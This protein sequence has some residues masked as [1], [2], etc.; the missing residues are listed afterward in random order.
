MRKRGFADKL[1]GGVSFLTLRQIV[2][3]FIGFGTTIILM[4]YL[5]PQNYGLYALVMGVIGLTAIASGNF[6]EAIRRYVPEYLARGAGYA[7]RRITIFVCATRLVLSAIAAGI[8]FLL[9]PYIAAFYN[10]NE[11]ADLLRIGSVL[12]V[13]GALSSIGINIFVG[14]Q[15]YSIPTLATTV[16][17]VLS[18]VAALSIA[19]FHFSLL[20]FVQIYVLVNLGFAVLTIILGWSLLQRKIKTTLLNKSSQ[21]SVSKKTLLRQVFSYC[22]PLW[23]AAINFT[24]YQ[25]ASKV[26]LGY[27]APIEV[28]GYFS[29]AKGVL[30]KL[31]NLYYQIPV[32]LLPALSE[33]LGMGEKRQVD[34]AVVALSK[35]VTALAVMMSAV[36][37]LFARELIMLIGGPRYT[38][39]IFLL[40]VLAVQFIFRLPANIWGTLYYIHERTLL[41]LWFNLARVIPTVVLL[42]AIVPY[43]SAKGAAAVEAFSYLT[44]MGLMIWHVPRLLGVQSL[45]LWQP[46]ARSCVTTIAVFGIGSVFLSMKQPAWSS[47]VGRVVLL[48]FVIPVLLFI[49]Q[50]LSREDLDSLERLSFA[51]KPF[52][53]LRNIA[54]GY[55]KFTYYSSRLLTRSR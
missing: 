20:Q 13:S 15:K 30:E 55:L 21:F 36:V 44:A 28:V 24:V 48:L 14:L 3:F 50:I 42:F 4:R 5:G 16:F 23:G 27:F 7:A 49:T 37:F 47:L 34:Q 43:F 33:K 54:L 39:A 11:M 32:T 26:I 51:W 52:D 22:W 12:F 19:I 2:Q 6:E 38:G 18:L 10:I 41:L 40:Q 29:V 8:V 35:W 31:T 46:L 1:V 17:G 45:S 25:H 9:A 53:K